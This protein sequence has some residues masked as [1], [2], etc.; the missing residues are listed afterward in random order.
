[1]YLLYFYIFIFYIFFYFFTFYFFF[2]C[3]LL[4]FLLK[5]CTTGGVLWRSN[6]PNLVSDF[7]IWSRDVAMV[8]KTLRWSALLPESTSSLH[9]KHCAHTQHVELSFH[10]TRDSFYSVLCSYVTSGL[11]SGVVVRGQKF[12]PIST[13]PAKKNLPIAYINPQSVNMYLNVETGVLFCVVTGMG[14]S[15]CWLILFFV[16]GRTTINSITVKCI[17]ISLTSPRGSTAT[18]V[19]IPTGFPRNARGPRDPHPRELSTR[20]VINSWT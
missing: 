20:T 3:S 17:R 1:M 10:Y 4:L 5:Y 7:E 15:S 8:L 18:S 9:F 11:P 16:T 12:V 19:C 6:A 2:L 14:F 13:F